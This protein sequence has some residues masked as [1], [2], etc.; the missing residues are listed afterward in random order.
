MK[1]NRK[2]VDEFFKEKLGR[3]KETP[4]ADVWDELDTRLDTL[5]PQAPAA[6]YR[7]LRHVAI[8]SLIV[9]L[10][11]SVVRKMTGNTG[12]A[13]YEGNPAQA[14]TAQN[15]TSAGS[16]INQQTASNNTAGVSAQQN[17]NTP[18]AG[19][20]E[21]TYKGNK[22]GNDHR[23]TSADRAIASS[24][25]TALHS[26][27]KS[28]NDHA[29]A[30]SDKAVAAE[31]IFNAALPQSV[32]QPPVMDNS[33][34]GPSFNDNASQAEPK[35]TASNTP[36]EIKKT[37]PA[38]GK[39]AI[40]RFEAGMKVGFETGTNSNAAGKYVIAPYLQY[41]LSP[42]VSVLMQPSVKYAT[43]NAR[44]MGSQS[45]YKEHGDS[46]V[47]SKTSA[48]I[49]GGTTEY[50]TTF[51]YS[52]THDSV[53]KSY[54]YRGTYMEFELPLLAKYKITQKL[55]AYG[56]I[57]L[58]YSKLTGITESTYTSQSIQKTAVITTANQD[59][60]A[61]A[62]P[63][64]TVLT[65]AGKPITDYT[66]SPY[67]AP[68]S[69]LLRVGYMVGFSY[70]YTEKWMFD[71]LMQQTSAPANIQG[72]YNTNSPLSAAYFRISVGYKFTK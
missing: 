62:S 45:Y 16:G 69:S 72:G 28:A 49:I 43:I 22:A 65:Y 18:L 35:K 70:E 21:N 15:S 17:D 10:G 23:K 44:N 54:S 25:H 32:D 48:T 41:N 56:G 30:S 67:A 33:K 36:T 19:V 61:V 9:F 46:T 14:G 34:G 13:P 26:T 38:A 29:V 64:N 20:G 47:N 52:Q 51:T 71:A 31:N 6:S 53:V 39:S 12:T 7:W 37:D 27:T 68:T 59:A 58:N 1:S 63:V 42:R 8:V 11:A 66:G 50:Q 3:Y 24:R 2:S 5:V 40:R 55:S 4:P 57:N 60:P